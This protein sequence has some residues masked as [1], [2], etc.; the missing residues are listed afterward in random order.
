MENGLTRMAS[1]TIEVLSI[2]ISPYL[3][4]A[5]FIGPNVQSLLVLAEWCLPNSPLANVYELA[6]QTHS[7]FKNQVLDKV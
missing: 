3:I 7:N 2:Y 6:F 4:I 5:A 1:T